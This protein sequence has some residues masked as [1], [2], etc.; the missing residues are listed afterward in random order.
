VTHAAQNLVPGESLGEYRL[1]R[2]IGRGAMGVVFEAAKPDGSL[3]AIKV[4]QP[5]KGADGEPE[6]RLRQRFL[7]EARALGAVDHP[8][9]VRVFEAGEAG[10]RLYLAMELLHGADLRSLIT[11]DAAVPVDRAVDIGVQLCAALEAV[12]HAGVVHRDVKPENV[13]VL[14][15]GGVKLT[16][17]G[18]AWMASEATLTQTGAVL[19]SPAYMS[20]EQILGGAVDRRSDLFSAAATLYHLV[21]GVLPFNGS[22]LIELAHRVAYEEPAP[23]PGHVPH[24]VARVILRGLRKSPAARFA[25]AAELGAALRA[26]TIAPPLS[27]TVLLSAGAPAPARAAHDRC[28]RHPR[29]DAV[30]A[31]RACGRPLCRGCARWDRPPFYCRVHSPIT[32]FGVRLE[33]LELAI[34]ALLF[35]LLL[36]SLTPAAHGTLFR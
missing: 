7:R 22:N 6:T 27:E 31:C 4:L 14:E 9:V 23:L 11:T 1:L 34:A 18:V 26:S 28:A 36:L 5:P 10:G 32:F 15:D 24:S 25:T 35:V 33:R 20:P 8:N 29:V 3:L 16:D 21:A 2:E 30:G 13:L 12:H 17:F 19:G